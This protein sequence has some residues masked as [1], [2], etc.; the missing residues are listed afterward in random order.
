MALVVQNQTH[1]LLFPR[2]ARCLDTPD[3]SVMQRQGQAWCMLELMV[4]G[5]NMALAEQQPAVDESLVI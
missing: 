4:G 3:T 2:V 5:P 1:W